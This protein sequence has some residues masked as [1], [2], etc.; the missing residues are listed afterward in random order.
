MNR[1]SFAQFM[2]TRCG[3]GWVVA[4][5][6]DRFVAKYGDQVPTISSEAFR[7][8]LRTY[9]TAWGDPYDDIRAEMYVALVAAG[10]ALEAA[11]EHSKSLPERTGREILQAIATVKSAIDAE[12]K[13]QL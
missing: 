11:R 5:R 6:T 1:P 9:A 4:A 13:R 8:L 2:N 7:G 12:Q 10:H 3:P